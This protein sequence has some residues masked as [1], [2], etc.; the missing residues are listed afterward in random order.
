MILLT[1]EADNPLESMTDK[2]LFNFYFILLHFT[3][4]IRLHQLSIKPTPNKRQ[5]HKIHLKQ[6]Q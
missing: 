2:I 5:I 6:G 1:P 3:L 4:A